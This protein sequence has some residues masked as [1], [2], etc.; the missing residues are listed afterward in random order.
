MPLS[1]QDVV[2][3]SRGFINRL[4]GRLAELAVM[5]EGLDTDDPLDPDLEAQ[6][7][8]LAHQLHGT[9]ASFG[10][11][12][13][14]SLGAVA[15]FAPPGQLPAAI[16]TLLDGVGAKLARDKQLRGR[17]VLLVG[18]ELCGSSLVGRVVRALQL[19]TTRVPTLAQARRC[20][21]ERTFD[22]VLLDLTLPDGDGRHLLS[23]Q[24]RGAAA[25]ACF[26]V[27]SAFVS[28][29]TRRECLGMGAEHF[30]DKPLDPGL[31]CTVIVSAMSRQ[32]RLQTLRMT[33]PLTGAG[34]RA[35]LKRIFG[36]IQSDRCDEPF[37]VSLAVVEID[38]FKRL[39]DA[40]GRAAGDEALRTV[41]AMLRAHLRRDL[42]HVVYWGSEEFV[43]LLE[44]SE[45]AEAARVL[46]QVARI[47]VQPAADGPALPI[48]VGLAQVRP[49]AELAE[50]LEAADAV[51]HGIKRSGRGPV[52]I[53]GAR[54]EPGRTRI[55]LVDDDLDFAACIRALLDEAGFEVTHV[56]TGP[57]ALALC[58]DEYAAVLLDHFMPEMAGID[59][60]A[61]LRVRHDTST[62]PVLMLTAAGNEEDIARAFELGVD[63]YVV[64]PC[65]PAELLARLRRMIIRREHSTPT[66]HPRPEVPDPT[67]DER[68]R[69]PPQARSLPSR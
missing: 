66:S 28:R 46:R 16:A 23:A 33:D 40:R 34:S 39:V 26:V 43:V 8:R 56:P 11:P 55:L 14:S 52:G 35:A 68:A 25:E 18:P 59:V 3:L 36:Q 24:P 19:V 41:A 7:R 44:R 21:A 30:L 62:L 12:V 17:H 29:Q 27:V 32:G 6:A 45:V 57:E 64:K 5:L 69:I 10:A 65:R 48:S 49:C 42:D 37:E 9:G 1:E 22:L 31:L 67:P 20:L 58:A 50:V 53:E 2:R 51:R 38:H 54:L 15:E 60:L 4:P 47:L 61:R 13:L 63:D